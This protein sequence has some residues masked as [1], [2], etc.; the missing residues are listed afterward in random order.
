MPA[1][2]CCCTDSLFSP[3]LLRKKKTYQCLTELLLIQQ[4]EDDQDDDEKEEEDEN[5][6]TTPSSSSLSVIFGNDPRTPIRTP[7]VKDDRDDKETSWGY[8][9]SIEEEDL[10]QHHHQTITSSPVSIFTACLSFAPP[11]VFDGAHTNYSNHHKNR[12]RPASLAQQPHCWKASRY[13][14]NCDNL[15]RTAHPGGSAATTI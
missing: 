6:K 13:S 5:H 9:F 15:F 11:P 4:E 8:H 2:S 14:Y 1:L 7:V 12:G 3:P 10:A